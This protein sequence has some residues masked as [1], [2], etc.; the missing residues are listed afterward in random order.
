MLIPRRLVAAG[1]VGLAVIV[2]GCGTR[3]DAA[4]QQQTNAAGTTG[5]ASPVA[6]IV[7][8]PAPPPFVGRDKHS[9]KLWA[10]TKQFYE[11]REEALIWTDRGKPRPQMDQLIDK[12]QHVD[13]EGLDPALYNAP[14][15]ALKRAEADRGWIVKKGFEP[16]QAADLDVAL[17][18][19]Y[20][21]YASD[22]TSGVGDLSHADPNWQIRAKKIDLL[23]TL[24]DAI[25]NNRVGQSLDGLLP[26]HRHYTALRDALAKYRQIQQ[27]G[28]WPQVQS[29]LRLKPGQQ[30]DAV[31]TL[32][33]RLAVTGDF[34]GTPDGTT[35][36]GPELQE[37][38]KKF[39]RRHG[40]EPDAVIGPAVIA[41]MNVPVEQ[42]IADIQ[43]N[44]ERW[45]W[46]PHDLGDRY[47]L[48]N[49]PEFRLEVWDQ[50]KVPLAMKVVVGKKDTPTPIFNDDMTQVVFAP[51]WNLPTSIVQKETL[52]RAIRDPGFLQRMNI[53]VLDKGGHA[54]D[55]S[56][57]DIDN[58]S[59]YRFRQRPGTSNSLGLVKF[60]FPNNF[61]VYLHDTPADSLFA[62]TTRMFSHGCVRVEQ[63]EDLARYV[64]ADQPEWTPE[65]IE[66]AMHAGQEHGV[67]LTRPL[68]VYLGY[69]TTRVSPDGLVQFRNDIYGIDAKQTS[70][71]AKV[72][73]SQ[74]AHAAKGD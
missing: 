15:L 11:T 32:A 68:P 60:V 23:A 18:Y 19:L 26:Q 38:V 50:G 56:T 74:K 45:R 52:P 61:N 4:Q 21:Q 42:R 22:V 57:V 25:D 47:V 66:E 40:L 67:K 16:D 10:L 3:M 30:S 31:V 34:A 1:T 24:A 6:R 70:M 71:L 48:V 33:R 58:P 53:E 17:T 72:I 13:R 63:P 46:L 9:Q 39:Q 20:L 8:A 12:L 36:Y 14:G 49:V 5:T 29:N 35:E 37:A 54:V 69:F 2:A 28:G 41:Q 51:Y 64:L 73:E 44:L 59:A 43:L 27:Q 7:D 62:R 65:R 55:P